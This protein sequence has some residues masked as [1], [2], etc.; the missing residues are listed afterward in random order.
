MKV[1]LSKN[2]IEAILADTYKAQEAGVKLN[3][4]DKK[5]IP[6]SCINYH[7]WDVGF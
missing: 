5:V 2:Q 6:N 1:K 7:D 4:C 3:F